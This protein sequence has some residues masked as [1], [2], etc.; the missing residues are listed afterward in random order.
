MHKVKVFDDSG[1]LK[2]VIS[3]KALKKRSDKIIESPS[4]FRKTH[5]NS[6][7]QLQS[8][9]ELNQITNRQ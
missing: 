7:P 3:V 5:V 2:K 4:L 1:N 6:K 8:D 9:K